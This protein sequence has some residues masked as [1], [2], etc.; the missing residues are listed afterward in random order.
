[1]PETP[2]AYSGSLAGL[3]NYGNALNPHPALPDD[4]A[5]FAALGK[6]V[7]S[8][9]SAENA[10]HMLARKLL[11]TTDAKARIVF[12]GM[13]LADLTDRIRGL[14]RVTKA[15]KRKY[16]EI[17]ACLTQ[18][19]LIADQRNK[20]VHRWSTYQNHAIWITNAP[21]SKDAATSETEAFSKLDFDHM[22]TDCVAIMYRLVKVGKKDKN[23]ATKRWARSPW[24]YKPARLNPQ[25][26]SRQKGA[27]EQRRQPRAS[28]ASRRRAAMER[29][30]Q[31]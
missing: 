8:Y 1:M 7:A 26:Q 14:L 2:S 11:R 18:L 5:L 13:R 21:N 20:V 6:F 28:R 17:D 4:A 10:V 12:G 3:V 31:K 15:A 16:E 23:L 9:A 30:Q 29:H 22:E 24:R 27:Q 19:N 25:N